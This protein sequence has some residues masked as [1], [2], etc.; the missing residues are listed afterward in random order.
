[1]TNT[2]CNGLIKNNNPKSPIAYFELVT[3]REYDDY[4]NGIIIE[5][6]KNAE[7][8]LSDDWGVLDEPFYQ[9]YGKRYID[10]VR[11]GSIFLGEFYSIEKAKEFLYNLTGEVPEIISY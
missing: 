11:T 7:Q 6:V 3:V 4:E 10:D 8:F 1:M 2:L 5:Q 9:I